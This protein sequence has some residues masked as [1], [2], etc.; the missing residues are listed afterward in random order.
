MYERKYSKV[1]FNLKN[2]IYLTLLTKIK[3]NKS[4]YELSEKVY[5]G[6]NPKK[7]VDV[8][9]IEEMAKINFNWKDISKFTSD[10][11]L[12]KICRNELY[13]TKE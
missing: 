10:L 6:A 7:V 3:L 9:I 2:F 13:I 11:I 1:F 5:T 8:E 4:R 12:F